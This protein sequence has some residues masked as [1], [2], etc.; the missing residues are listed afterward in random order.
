MQLRF[1][2]VFLVCAGCGSGESEAPPPPPAPSMAACHWGTFTND[3]F[4][5]DDRCLDMTGPAMA[6]LDD[7]RREC[8]S[9]NHQFRP[10]ESC[11]TEGR[12]GSCVEGVGRGRVTRYYDHGSR[13]WT[14]PS[15]QSDCELVPSNSFAPN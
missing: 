11:P 9:G 7:A 2:L 5:D 1:F 8:E 10:G 14:T 13:P 15:A 6:A 4:V 12:V 3:R